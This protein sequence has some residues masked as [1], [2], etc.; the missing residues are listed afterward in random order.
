MAQG[1]L[2][3]GDH[4]LVMMTT[5]GV[6]PRAP[7]VRMFVLHLTLARY[8]VVFHVF[9][10]AAHIFRSTATDTSCSEPD[11]ETENCATRRWYPREDKYFAVIVVV[12]EPFVKAK[13]HAGESFGRA[14]V[15]RDTY[16][17]SNN[18]GAEELPPLETFGA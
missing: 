7:P 3:N 5:R 11:E 8:R 14:D 9:L 2:V 16:D 17:R 1:G 4:G 13:R 18:Q 15:H 10:T 12:T 6:S